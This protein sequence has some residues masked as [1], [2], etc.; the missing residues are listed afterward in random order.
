MMVTGS[1]PDDT[2]ILLAAAPSSLAALE[3]A[4]ASGPFR[5][6]AVADADAALLALQLDPPA[7]A[8]V[9]LDL[10]GGGLELPRRASAVPSLRGLP[11]IVAGPGGAA[12]ALAAGA[13]D[14]V[15][16][17]IDGAE[18]LARLQGALRA[19]RV[20]RELARL[21]DELGPIN[22]L[23]AHAESRTR[24][25]LQTAREAILLLDLDGTIDELNAAAERTFGWAEAD[26]AGHA[27]LEEMIAPV[28]R[29]LIASDLAGAAGGAAAPVR[30]V[31]ALRRAG[32]EFSAEC[33]ITRIETPAGGQLCAF[34]RDLTDAKRLELELRQAQKLESVGRLSAGIAHEINT[35]IQFIG[36]NTKFQEEAFTAMSRML[37]AQRA[38]LAARAP[39]V[40]PELEQL[41][42][43]LDLAYVLEQ[44]PK[45]MARTLEGVRRVATIVRA[46]KE[47][48]HPDRKD[49]IAVDLNRALDA[50]LEVARNEYKLVAD[51]ETAFGEVPMVTCHA[52]EVNQV[53]LNLIVNAAHAIADVV[54]GAGGKGVIRVST[55]CERDEVEV[56]VADTGG[57]IPAAI[58]DKIFDPFFTTKEV[59]RGTG[60]GLT[61]ARNVVDRHRG[62]IRFETEPGRGTTFFIRLPITPPTGG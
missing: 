40:L 21:S 52:N 29:P 44:I 42:E 9:S 3:A 13:A 36:D 22:Q 59:G 6:T 60:Q 5:L 2:P 39:D 35:P 25:I 46:M 47:F 16:F 53:F 32:Q 34:V 7:A 56:A 51:V 58:Q 26:A 30:E 41:G 43:E 12:A 45:T 38:A 33:R 17:P 62:T 28:S 19:A 14:F 31:V 1:S 55:R 24:A 4:L 27:F 18:L 23:L 57:G 20:G 50:T 61:I 15:P 11:V 37:D 48:A 10:P 49:K 8:V 54:K